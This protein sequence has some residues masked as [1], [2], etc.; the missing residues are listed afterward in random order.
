VNATGR[1]PV[2][3]EVVLPEEMWENLHLVAHRRGSTIA[4]E[5]AEAIVAHLHH[6]APDLSPLV[7]LETEL[8]RARRAG[9]RTPGHPTHR[10][11]TA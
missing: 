8:R 11:A 2:H 3:V 6:R 10:K 7:E 1:P 5:I 9:Y 4:G